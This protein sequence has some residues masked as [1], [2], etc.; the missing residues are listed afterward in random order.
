[1]QAVV[2][3]VVA[4]RSKAEGWESDQKR[5]L[6]YGLLKS[7]LFR[8]S[9]RLRCEHLSCHCQYTRKPWLLPGAMPHARLW[10]C[11]DPTSDKS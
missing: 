3:P 9:S 5:F 7:C 4:A 11:G 2:A 8:E 1:M 6:F 10:Y